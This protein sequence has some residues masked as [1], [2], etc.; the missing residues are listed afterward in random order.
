MIDKIIAYINMKLEELIQ[1]ENLK[2]V[3]KNLQPFIDWKNK[4]KEKEINNED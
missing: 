3:E 4:Q 2:R 1:E